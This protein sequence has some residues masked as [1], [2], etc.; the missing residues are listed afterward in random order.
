VAAV[1]VVVRQKVQVVARDV[2][3]LGILGGPEAHQRAGQIFVGE[4]RLVGRGHHQRHPF[5]RLA[6]GARFHIIEVAVD[7]HC[8]EAVVGVTQPVKGRHEVDQIGT[9]IKLERGL[10]HEV[11]DNGKRAQDIIRHLMDGAIAAH[12]KTVAIH[13]H[14]FAIELLEGA[15]TVVAMLPER[16]HA[17]GPLIH[18]LHQGC[19]GGDLKER[20]VRH[21][22]IL[23]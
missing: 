18:P 2:H 20:T 6:H 12:L 10:R 8:K 14:H 5:R 19:R 1:L 11:G 7:T 16:S 23:G 13:H 17:H 15:Q 22:Q 4:F 3:G 21:L 9:V